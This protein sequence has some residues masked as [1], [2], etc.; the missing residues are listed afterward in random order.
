MFYRHGSYLSFYSLYFAFYGVLA[1][2]WYVYM[3]SSI[4]RYTGFEWPL[5]ASACLRA[6]LP[7]PVRIDRACALLNS[8]N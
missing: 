4:L 1:V 8:V 2:R 3:V 5:R 6:Y 7:L